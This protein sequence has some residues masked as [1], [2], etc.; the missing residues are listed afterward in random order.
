VKKLF[1]ALLAFAIVLGISIAQP[2]QA[3][4]RIDLKR[5]PS[6]TVAEFV[7]RKSA[8]CPSNRACAWSGYWDSA[9]QGS[10]WYYTYARLQSGVNWKS[11]SADLST[12]S[13]Y[14][15]LNPIGTA[16][17]PYMLMSNQY[18]C[19]TSPGWYVRLASGQVA[20]GRNPSTNWDHAF[21]SVFTQPPPSG[22]C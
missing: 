14:N 10:L 19:V 5:G 12:S 20:N 21:R 15:R 9:D 1:A 17:A 8:A 3:N 7:A 6:E 11:T 13:W 18:N 4:G 22:G 16:G 2:V